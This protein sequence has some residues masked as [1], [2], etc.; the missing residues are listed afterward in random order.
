[1]LAD[2]EFAM[3]FFGMHLFMISVTAPG[4][5]HVDEALPAS[6]MPVLPSCSD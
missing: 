5:Y 6:A 2:S 3:P 1:M 4:L